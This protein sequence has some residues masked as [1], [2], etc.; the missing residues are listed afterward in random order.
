[1]EPLQQSDWLSALGQVQ[2]VVAR[3]C[4]GTAVAIGLALVVAGA[5][6]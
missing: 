4:L 1:M 3:V 6:V 5:P 2:T